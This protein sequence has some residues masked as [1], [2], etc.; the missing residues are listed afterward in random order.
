MAGIFFFCLHFVKT[1]IN[2]VI[3]V[4]ACST[5]GLCCYERGQTMAALHS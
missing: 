1:K 2:L 3:S 5:H 4:N